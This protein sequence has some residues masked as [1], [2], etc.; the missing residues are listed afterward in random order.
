[1]NKNI[2]LGSCIFFTFSLIV[3]L[4]HNFLSHEYTMLWMYNLVSKTLKKDFVSETLVLEQAK[5]GTM[6]ADNYVL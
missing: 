3:Q 5:R 6:C 2:I 1:M 4:K